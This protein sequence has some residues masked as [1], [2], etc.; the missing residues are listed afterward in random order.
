MI[1]NKWRNALAY[2]PQ[3]ILFRQGPRIYSLSQRKTY[4]SFWLINWKHT[5][6]VMK[7]NSDMQRR[8]IGTR[9]RS[10]R[11]GKRRQGGYR[12]GY[13]FA[14]FC[15]TSIFVRHARVTTRFNRAA[16][17]R[18]RVHRTYATSTQ[19][20][21]ARFYLAK[22]RGQCFQTSL[23]LTSQFLAMASAKKY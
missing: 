7:R 2:E 14:P 12:G 11:Q 5:E 20:S 16:I 13:R 9:W 19:I 6:Y 17:N 23:C 15:F 10:S 22:N 18:H 8:I 3:V 21:W 1:V 4:R